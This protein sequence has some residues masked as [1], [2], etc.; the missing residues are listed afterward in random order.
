MSAAWSI[1][2]GVTAGT[3]VVAL[4]WVGSVYA[5][6]RRDRARMRREAARGCLRVIDGVR[7]GEP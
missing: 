6:I 3:G 4:R 1:A 5:G 2:I 7:E